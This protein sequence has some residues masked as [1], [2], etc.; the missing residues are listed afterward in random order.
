MTETTKYRKKPAVVEAR[1]FDGMGNLTDA[2]NLAEWCGGVFRY[3]NMPGQELKTYY[4]W[5]EIPT[6]EGTM[7]AKPGDY[8]IKGVQG[9][10]Y[11]CKPDIFAE[12]YEAADALAARQPTEGDR[13]AMAEK[14]RTY[15]GDGV[16]VCSRDASAWAHGTMTL[17]DFEVLASEDDDTIESLVEIALSRAAVPDAAT[18]RV[19]DAWRKDHREML[20]KLDAATAA[21]ARVRAIH[22]PDPYDVSGKYCTCEEA[23]PCSTIAALDG[24]PEPEEGP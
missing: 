19:R 11:P 16:Y 14:F 1:K 12:T 4:W 13:E 22:H 7:R 23:W 21:I 8:I 18:E 6:L 10:F 24:A 9:E 5:I 15:L 20:A 17:E 3:D 2:E